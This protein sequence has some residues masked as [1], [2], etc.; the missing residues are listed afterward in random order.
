MLL[1]LIK[2]TPSSRDSKAYNAI[3]KTPTCSNECAKFLNLDSFEISH[4][5][6][7][8]HLQ[9]SFSKKRNCFRVKCI[10]NN[11]NIINNGSNKYFN[12][13]DFT[14]AY[15]YENDVLSF[16]HNKCIYIFSVKSYAV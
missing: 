13:D 2:L 5:S 3:V 1:E 15:M 12:N 14:E 4:E 10:D 6:A 7:G 9:F 16:N 8:A 11:I